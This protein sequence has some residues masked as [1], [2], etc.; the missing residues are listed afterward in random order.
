MQFR[1]FWV[2]VV[3]TDTAAESLNVFLASHSVVNADVQFV[4]SGSMV[5]WAISVQTVTTNR[6]G[7]PGGAG[8]SGTGVDA[9]GVEY[10]RTS[11]QHQ[12]GIVLTTSEAEV[13]VLTSPILHQR[14]AASPSGAAG[15]LAA[16]GS[17]EPLAPT[18]Q[19][20]RGLQGRWRR[21][22]AANL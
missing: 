21:G 16:G 6:S 15:A 10:D 4:Q 5:G 8:T 3:S 18:G 1:F 9:A 11:G 7:N 19:A 12:V 2:P 13:R 17:H 20:R 22:V 14:Y